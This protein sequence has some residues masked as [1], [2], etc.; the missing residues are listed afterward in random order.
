MVLGSLFPLS[1]KDRRNQ[2]TLLILDKVQPI[3]FL[4]NFHPSSIFLSS[5]CQH[6]GNRAGG[7]PGWLARLSQ[8]THV[9]IPWEI[10]RWQIV[11]MH[12]FWLRVEAGV[13]SK[14][15]QNMQTA[16]TH[17]RV[18]T[19]TTSC[20]IWG[21]STTHPA[22]I[23]ETLEWWLSLRAVQTSWNKTENESNRFSIFQ[24][25]QLKLFHLNISDVQLKCRD[26]K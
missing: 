17:R 3:D 18:R 12:V 1:H 25:K 16:Y 15:M 13:P 6:I 20:E 14:H 19:Q 5:T 7:H 24:L 4:Q 2:N 10:R 26:K 23:Y 21:N 9:H 22:T 11:Q 8:W